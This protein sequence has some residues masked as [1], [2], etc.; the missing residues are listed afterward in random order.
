VRVAAPADK[1]FRR[2]HVRPTRRRQSLVTRAV[3]AGRIAGG[4]LF[5]VVGG[6]MFTQ[7][8]AQARSLH[9]DRIL[10]RGNSRLPTGEV[11]ALLEGLKGQH[12]LAVD[13]ETWRRRVL[14]SPWVEYAALRRVLP[15]TI[16][17]AIREREPMALGR[18]GGDDGLYLVDATGHVIDE[19][20]PNYAQFDLP[21]VDGLA[22][23]RPGEPA[24]DLDRA[25]LANRLIGALHRAPSLEKR[26]SQ[27]SVASDRDAV[28]LLEGDTALL[29]LGDEQ[30]AER[31]QNWIDLAAAVR[32]QVPEIE[33]VDLRFQNRV[34]VRPAGKWTKAKRDAAQTGR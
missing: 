6:W 12:L 16:E 18:V 10:V 30:F 2:A 31:L 11:I 3:A 26:V 17:V 23:N 21:I 5:L 13:L 22:P 29:H 14:N 27:I 7:Q 15:S 24:I 25:L 33:S 20:G 9:V 19:F 4:L 34:Y 32:Q 1:R 8:V 28:V